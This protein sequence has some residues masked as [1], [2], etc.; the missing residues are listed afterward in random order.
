MIIINDERLL[1]N[2]A[3]DVISW[4]TDDEGERNY[5][6]IGQL[7]DRYFETNW[8]AIVFYERKSVTVNTKS[9]DDEGTRYERRL[10]DVT[11]RLRQMVEV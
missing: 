6:L 7:I 2:S 11:K 9:S 1:L 10:E 5:C 3:F 8:G 4:C